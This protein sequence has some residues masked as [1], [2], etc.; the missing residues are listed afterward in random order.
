MPLR[1]LT[2]EALLPHLLPTV[3]V[4]AALAGLMHV[5]AHQPVVV[6][7]TAALAFFA[8]LAIY[9]LL[10]AGSD[11]AQRLRAALPGGRRGRRRRSAD[12]VGA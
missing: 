9:L 4:G 11:E 7:G 3:L 8:Y 10:N 6:V 12:R 2:R 1:R 5:I